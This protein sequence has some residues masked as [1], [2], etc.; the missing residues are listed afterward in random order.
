MKK[1]KKSLAFITT[2]SMLVTLA[3][4]N[5]NDKESS[6]E[7]SIAEITE[8]NK[9]QADYDKLKQDYDLL[10]SDYNKVSQELNEIKITSTEEPTKAADTKTENN[11]Q[12]LYED[13]CVKITYKGIEKE[14][15]RTKLNLTIENLSDKGITV[16]ARDVSVNEIMSKPIFSCDIVAGKKANDN[17]TFY[18]LEDDGINNIETVEFSFHVYESNSHETIVDTEMIKINITD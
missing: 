9:L 7:E 4:C 16:Q 13:D 15:S 8:N 1:L 3:A 10:L 6:K 2:V 12:I 14:A 17:M 18:N 11:D 5:S